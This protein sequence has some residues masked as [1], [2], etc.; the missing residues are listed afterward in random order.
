MIGQLL[1]LQLQMD[2]DRLKQL[3]RLRQFLKQLEQIRL[4][5]LHLFRHQSIRAWRHRELV[6]LSLLLQ[7]LLSQPQPELQGLRLYCLILLIELENL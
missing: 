3:K 5:V 1:L 4:R 6:P 2:L 7:L